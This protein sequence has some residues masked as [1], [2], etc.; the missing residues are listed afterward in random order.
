MFRPL[1]PYLVFFL[2]VLFIVVFKPNVFIFWHSCFIIFI[3]LFIILHNLSN[4]D[5]HFDN[6]EEVDA[7]LLFFKKK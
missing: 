2:L 3:I 5:Y 4:V 6:L 1:F 7:I